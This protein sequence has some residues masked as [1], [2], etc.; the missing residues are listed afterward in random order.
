LLYIRL[1]LPYERY[2]KGRNIEKKQSKQP[3]KEEA[4]VKDEDNESVAD[5]DDVLTKPRRVRLPPYPL[6]S[7]SVSRYL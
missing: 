5:P 4:V 3:I 2:D 7:E 1:L 6:L